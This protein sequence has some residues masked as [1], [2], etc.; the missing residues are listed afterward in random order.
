L[1]ALG[2]VDNQPLLRSLLGKVKDMFG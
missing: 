2:T 1:D